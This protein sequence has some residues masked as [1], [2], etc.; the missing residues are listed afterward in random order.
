MLANDDDL[1]IVSSTIELCRN[2][3]WLWWPMATR[4]AANQHEV[5]AGVSGKWHLSHGHVCP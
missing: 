4:R 5:A 3:G 2:L 1:A